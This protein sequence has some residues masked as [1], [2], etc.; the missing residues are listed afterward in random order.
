MGNETVFRNGIVIKG[1][2]QSGYVLSSDS[3]G[4]AS[5]TASRAYNYFKK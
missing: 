5:W 2:E 1:G 3:S 4:I